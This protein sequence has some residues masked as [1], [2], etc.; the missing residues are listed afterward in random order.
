MAQKMTMADISKQLGIS[1]MTVSRYFNGGY[2]SEEN[3]L[4][5]DAIVKENHYTLIICAF[6]SQ[7]I[8]YYW[9]YCAAY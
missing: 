7:S 3:R 2:V 1:K 8:K 4:K 5:I 6:Y 9:F